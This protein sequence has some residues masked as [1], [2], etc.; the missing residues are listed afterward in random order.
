MKTVRWRLL[1]WNNVFRDV[2][3]MSRK[4]R[5]FE[6]RVGFLLSRIDEWSS[7][8]IYINIF[9]PGKVYKWKRLRNKT[10]SFL[11]SD[12]SCKVDFCS[13]GKAWVY[14]SINARSVIN[15]LFS[16]SSKSVSEA[17]RNNVHD[18]YWHL[19]VKP[20]YYFAL[21]TLYIHAECTLWRNNTREYDI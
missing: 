9:F 4:S 5:C 3:T 1:I 18:M 20:N 21:V 2:T 14:L 13:F 6:C 10:S 8:V 17:T 11:S 15:I 19:A 16:G 12:R 7:S